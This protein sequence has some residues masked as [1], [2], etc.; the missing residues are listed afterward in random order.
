MTS[1]LLTSVRTFS[2]NKPLVRIL[3]FNFLVNGF[4]IARLSDAGSK[5]KSDLLSILYKRDCIWGSRQRMVN[6]K[7]DGGKGILLLAVPMK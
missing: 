1:L 3:S 4:L 7:L 6:V 2:A 5:K